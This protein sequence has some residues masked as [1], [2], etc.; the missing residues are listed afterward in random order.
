MP[1]WLTLSIIR[2]AS[3]V[4][5]VNPG[6][7][8]APSPT[9]WCSSYRKGSLRDTLNYSHQLTIS[10]F[11]SQHTNY[12]DDIALLANTPT[13]AETP[14]YSLERA[15]GGI[16]LHV[17]ADKKEYM[18]FNQRGDISTLNCGPLKAV[19]KFTYLGRRVSS[20]EKDINT[21]LANAWRAT[22]RLSVIWKS[23]LSVKIKIQF[24]SK[25]RS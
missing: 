17:N 1:P 21:R 3:R 4:K 5:W 6:K 15:A 24:F 18:C 14:L 12:A 20:I 9:P 23:G 11:F 8:V 19:D 13:Q 2:Y 10:Y 25:Q 16:S 7:E 22:D